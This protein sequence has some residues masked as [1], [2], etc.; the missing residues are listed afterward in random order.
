MQAKK[1]T[2]FIFAR[3]KQTS[4]IQNMN[5]KLINMIALSVIV[6]AS[7]TSKPEQKPE[8]EKPNPFLSEYTTPFQVPPFDQIKNEHYLPAFEAGIAEQQ[9]EIDAIVNNAETPTFE[10]TILPYDKSGQTLNR[11]SNVFFNLNECLTNDE[12]V[13]IAEQVL[14]MLSKHSDAI[15]MNPKLFERIDY[16]YQHRNEM[17]LDDQQIRVVEKYHQ[18]FM[19]HGAGLNAEQQAELSQINE[20][21]STLSLQFGNNLLKENAGYKLVIENEADLAGLPQTSIDAAAEQ[22]KA[23]G[24]EGKWV[25][26][27]SKPSLIPFLQFADNRDLREQMYKAYY[28]RGDNNNEYDN[29]KLVNEMCKLRVQKAKLFGFDNYADYVLDVNMAKD[30]KTVDKFLIDIFNPAQKLAKK[31][32]AEMQ[33]IADKEGANI[34]LEG[35]DWWYYAEKLRKAKYDFDENYIKPY[36]TVDNV[37]D[38]MF[39]A[40]RMLYGVTFTKNETLPIYY[41]G[42][43][44]YEV[45]EANGDLLGILYMDY[46]PRESKSGGAWCT[47]FRESGHDINGKKIYPVVSLVMNFTP[48]SGDTPALLTWDETETM[49]HEFGHSLHAFFSD[50]LYTRTCG[51]VPHDYVEMPSQIMENWVAEP[52]VIR[53]YAKHYQ[54][55]EVMPDSLIAKI[56]N[57]ALFN[58]GFMTTEL[59]AASILD[60][61][62]HELTEPQDLD[63]DAFEKQQMDAIGLMPEILPRYRSTNF[64]HIFNGGYS[65]GYYA[66]T[67]AEVL[68]K[69]AFNYFKSSGD[70][71]N[72]DLAASFRKNCLQECGNDEGMVQYRKFRGQDPDYEPYLKARGLK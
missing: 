68:D 72:P 2:F 62:Y 7:C 43:E 54:T 32:L 53:M 25:F 5:K 66:Y 48:A 19:R 38:G 1:T 50:G 35:W 64:A 15:M 36:L 8:A 59:I 58:Q 51:N 10:N 41:P 67:W 27:L 3:E 47:S 39:L 30:S 24:M 9:A 29:K 21:L 56:E 71:F 37:R 16:V 31:E 4:N 6:L 28:N 22:A 14:P 33:A 69:D 60:M 44:T 18:D 57:S 49:W 20:Q 40:A 46:Y 23:D 13:A 55:G 63:V 11:V 26:T 45:K 42:V 61:K 34:K 65:A 12:M 70:L 52:E 17:G